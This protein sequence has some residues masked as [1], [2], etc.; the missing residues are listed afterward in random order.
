M[1]DNFTLTSPGLA[2]PIEINSLGLR[3]RP[4]TP[5]SVGNV[6]APFCETRAVRVQLSISPL[7]ARRIIRFSDCVLRIVQFFWSSYFSFLE[8]IF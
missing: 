1:R 7:W 6:L 4:P 5:F 3:P 2:E 8:F